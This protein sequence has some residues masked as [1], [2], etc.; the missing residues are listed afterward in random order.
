MLFQL[1]FHTAV[2][3]TFT[4]MTQIYLLPGIF[5]QTVSS[6]WEVWMT[7]S[8]AQRIAIGTD[9]KSGALLCYFIITVIF[10]FVLLSFEITYWTL[11]S[12]TLLKFSSSCRNFWL[13]RVTSILAWQ[14]ILLGLVLRR[15][16]CT[17]RLPPAAADSSWTYARVGSLPRR[18]F[19]TIT[20]EE[21]TFQ[22]VKRILSRVFRL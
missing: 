1:R 14:H 9:N 16:K 15:H 22:W 2:S 13:F 12:S 5:Q 21:R 20:W 18:P 4:K 3:I 11:L 19:K 6:Y 7:M 17:N 8:I 10:S